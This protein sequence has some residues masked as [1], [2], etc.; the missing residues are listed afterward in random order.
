A[1]AAA[2]GGARARA[3]RVSPP[4]G[5][6]EPVWP[7]LAMAAVLVAGVVW[8]AILFWPRGESRQTPDDDKPK[9][10]EGP[11]LLIATE[12][13]LDLLADILEM[14][15]ASVSERRRQHAAQTARRSSEYAA[16]KDAR[17]RAAA[18]ADEQLR[19]T[20]ARLPA[21]PAQ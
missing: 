2:G 14:Q 4:P 15:T 13:G 7:L 17:T 16:E 19:R 10:E 3:A 21:G 20:R 9:G 6:G 11:T 1:G 12:E 18:T 5:R 8:V